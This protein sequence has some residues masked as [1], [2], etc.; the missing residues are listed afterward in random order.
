MATVFTKGTL[1]YCNPTQVL[2]FTINPV[3]AV[4]THEI[5]L[6]AGFLR[7]VS[8]LMG[9]LF[10]QIPDDPAASVPITFHQ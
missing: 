7:F 4:Q 1:L 2:E 10:E 6:L 3:T 8:V 9:Q 5:R